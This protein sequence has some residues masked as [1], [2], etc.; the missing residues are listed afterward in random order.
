MAL[1][2]SA[3]DLV[4]EKIQ[5]KQKHIIPDETILN[6][7]PEDD[8]NPT[9]ATINFFNKNVEKKKIN[10][11]LNLS[12]MNYKKHIITHSIQIYFLLL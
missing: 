12:G 11:L 7:K 8:P 9:Y 1:K 2:N 5:E 3:E 4:F 10:P 6:I